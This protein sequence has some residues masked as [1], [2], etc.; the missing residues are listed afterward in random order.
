MFSAI[1]VEREVQELPRVQSILLRFDSL[2]VIHIEQ[3]GEIFNRNRQNFRLQKQQPALI[4]AA[5]HGHK[6][7]P[8]PPGYG[9][10]HLLDPDAED[11]AS[12]QGRGYYFSHMLNCVYDCRYCFLQGMYRSANYVLFVNYEDF[13]ADIRNTALSSPEPVV[14]Y[15]GYDCDSLALEPVSRFVDYYLPLFAELPDA[16]LEIRTKSTQ[17]R[18]LLERDALKNCVIAMSFS[19]R[20]VAEQLEH[21]VPAIDKRIEALVRLQK[22]G[23]PVA[24]RFEPVIASATTLADYAE[25]F[26][27][28]FSKL[29][30]VSL[31]SCSLGEFRLPQNYYKRMVKLYPDEPLLAR[32]TSEKGGLISLE[33]EESDLLGQLET[34]LFNH[35]NRESY[36]RC[37]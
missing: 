6:V 22:S 5:K 14:F 21:K 17:V 25:L 28:I 1:Y 26:D 20:S 8:T 30:A 7:L 19:P 31:H 2:P 33:Y 34:L 13:A 3:Y 35:V 16:S 36:Y 4:L 37:A 27:T 15:S 32:E 18:F 23:W 24:L 12:R 11:N 9:F 10:E 29:D